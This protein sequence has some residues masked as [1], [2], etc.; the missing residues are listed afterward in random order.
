MRR[1]EEYEQESRGARRRKRK[2]AM[3]RKILGFCLFTFLLGVLCG[4]IVFA[5]S[6]EE[7]YVQD[8]EEYAQQA[9]YGMEEEEW[10][11]EPS[12][13]EGISGKLLT[14]GTEAGEEEAWMLTLVNK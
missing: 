10:D 13:A 1:Y 4:R 2:Q 14:E 8:M 9:E 6:A 12:K 5:K 3:Q 7:D 11:Q